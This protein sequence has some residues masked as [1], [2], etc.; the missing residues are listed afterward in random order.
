[1]APHVKEYIS[2]E[3]ALSR[4]IESDDNDGHFRSLKRSAVHS[5][6]PCFAFRTTSN[7][8]G[9]WVHI[10]PTDGGTEAQR[11]RVAFLWSHSRMQI[12]SRFDWTFKGLKLNK[13]SA[14]KTEMDGEPHD[15]DAMVT[16]QELRTRGQDGVGAL[17]SPGS[18]CNQ[19]GN[20]SQPIQPL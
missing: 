7:L 2:K 13:M 14:L 19:L 17:L 8:L 4:P 10:H 3:G 15:A 18:L 11:S 20:L 16:E 12:V 9:Q 1:M 5:V 6:I